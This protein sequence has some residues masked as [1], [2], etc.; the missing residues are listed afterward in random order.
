MTVDGFALYYTDFESLY[1]TTM[2]GGG[3]NVSLLETHWQAAGGGV[4]VK[5]A[6]TLD[7]VPMS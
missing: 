5:D 1:G 2:F 3:T 6:F 7:N 4:R